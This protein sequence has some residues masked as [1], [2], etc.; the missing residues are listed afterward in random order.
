MMEELDGMAALTEGVRQQRFPHTVDARVW[1]AE[2]A[3]QYP[4]IDRDTMLG[5]FANAIMAGFDTAGMRCS[6]EIQQLKVQGAQARLATLEEVQRELERLI[7]IE[8][9]RRDNTMDLYDLK[10]WL[11]RQIAEGKG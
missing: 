4:D 11:D 9:D 5:W 2:F 8:D 10:G 6:G 3:K 7:A 1:V